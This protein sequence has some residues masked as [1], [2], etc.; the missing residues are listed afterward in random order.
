[1]ENEYEWDNDWE[2]GGRNVVYNSFNTSLQYGKRCGCEWE[3]GGGGGGMTKVRAVSERTQNKG[4]V[5]AL[6][7]EDGPC[8]APGVKTLFGASDVALVGAGDVNA[9]NVLNSTLCNYNSAHLHEKD[10]NPRAGPLTFEPD[11]LIT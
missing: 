6:E 4:S 9:T 5:V 10:I 7:E 1:M 2:G 3:S 8:N 11:T